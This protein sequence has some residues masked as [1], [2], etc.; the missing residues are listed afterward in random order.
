MKSKPSQNHNLSLAAKKYR[1]QDENEMLNQLITKYWHVNSSILG[2]IVQYHLIMEPPH[3]NSESI[4]H[5]NLSLFNIA[6]SFDLGK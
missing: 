2:I 5:R 6:Y 1:Q 4:E 3:I